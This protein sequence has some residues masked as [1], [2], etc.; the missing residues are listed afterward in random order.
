MVAYDG[1]PAG[2]ARM[3]NNDNHV[4]SDC[5]LWRR[6]RN[7]EDYSSGF[8]VRKDWT[9]KITIVHNVNK[10]SAA[11]MGPGGTAAHINAMLVRYA[12]TIS[13]LYHVTREE[14]VLVLGERR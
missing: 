10:N 6:L 4:A 3:L 14:N 2:I 7:P 12:A 1:K 5:P 8:I 13:R 9:G 11:Q